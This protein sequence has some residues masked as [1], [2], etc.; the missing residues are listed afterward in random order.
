MY[1]STVI[2]INN[3]LKGVISAKRI[4]KTT[5]RINFLLYGAAY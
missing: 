2:L 5:E 3:G 1:L 4:A